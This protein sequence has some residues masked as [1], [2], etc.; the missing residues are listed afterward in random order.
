MRLLGYNGDNLSAPDCSVRIT[1]GR[2]ARYEAGAL[3]ES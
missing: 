3:A 1:G 2:E